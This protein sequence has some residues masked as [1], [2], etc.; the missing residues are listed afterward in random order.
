MILCLCVQQPG[1][2]LDRAHGDGG[3]SQMSSGILLRRK[4][5]N[6]LL[7]RPEEYFNAIC[8]FLDLLLSVLLLLFYNVKERSAVVVFMRLWWEKKEIRRHC[9]IVRTRSNIIIWC[10][11]FYF[12]LSFLEL[13]S[14]KRNN[15]AVSVD[16]GLSLD[17]SFVLRS[18]LNLLK[19][20]K[21]K[22]Y[23]YKF[24]WIIVFFFFAIIEISFNS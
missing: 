16:D 17:K 24:D 10:M 4:K 15:M 12:G 21:F 7:L 23:L 11:M 19:S 8:S 13:T 3:S 1:S 20:F 22:K 2:G 18:V 9:V 6:F 5:C 14:L